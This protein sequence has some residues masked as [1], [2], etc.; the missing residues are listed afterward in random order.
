MRRQGGGTAEAA[1]MYIICYILTIIA[2]FPGSKPLVLLLR[3]V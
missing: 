2:P 1:V 3:E